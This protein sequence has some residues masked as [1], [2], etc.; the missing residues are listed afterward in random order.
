MV[1]EA[2]NFSPF[3]IKITKTN[4]TSI[5]NVCIGSNEECN[6]YAKHFTT[7][8]DALDSEDVVA[9]DIIEIK[10]SG[11]YELPGIISKNVTIKWAVSGVIFAHDA[12]TQTNNIANIPNWVTFENVTFNLKEPDSDPY[13]HGFGYSD[14]GTKVHNT[15]PIIFRD[16]VINGELTT[17]WKTEFYNTTFNIDTTLG[18][19][20]WNVWVRYGDVKFD[21]CTFNGYDRNIHLHSNTGAAFQQ[22]RWTVEVKDCTFWKSQTKTNKSAIIIKEIW[23]RTPVTQNVSW[24]WYPTKYDVVIT[25]SQIKVWDESKYA[26]I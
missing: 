19:S 13:Y 21:G 3:F 8:K 15:T 5:D 16:C 9:G 14:I 22:Q 18:K 25:N 2:D 24:Y 7:L 4:E 10:E 17:Y 1:I 20:L 6:G 12:R 26:R 11:E 23:S